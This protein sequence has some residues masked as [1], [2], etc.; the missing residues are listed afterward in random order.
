MHHYPK[1][2]GWIEASCSCEDAFFSA[3][4]I[5][6]LLASRRTFLRRISFSCSR[7]SISEINSSKRFE[8]CPSAA[9]TQSRIQRSRFSAS[10]LPSAVRWQRHRANFL[11]RLL[12]AP[13]IQ[14]QGQTLFAKFVGRRTLQ[15]IFAANNFVTFVMSVLVSKHRD[16][17][18]NS[19]N[20][21]DGQKTKTRLVPP[22]AL[23]PDRNF[24]TWV[25][26]PRLGWAPLIGFLAN[27]HRKL[28][29]KA[30]ISGKYVANKT[31]TAF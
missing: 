14:N 16:K 20:F 26:L 9:S 22:R 27:T 12:L 23:H 5:T 30:L 2:A 31:L 4:S 29:R 15:R 25:H 3:A 10:I 13:L 24:A 11:E 18:H 17:S 19:T 6:Y 7:P 8:S 21:S 1:S 28:G